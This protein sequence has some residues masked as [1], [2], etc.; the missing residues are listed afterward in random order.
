MY[1][2]GDGL[3]DVCGTDRV[4]D[5]RV[6]TQLTEGRS[7]QLGLPLKGIYPGPTET[8]T[9]ERFPKSPVSHPRR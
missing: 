1:L 9:D 6:D 2:T 7:P 5:T 3:P 4:D 8:V